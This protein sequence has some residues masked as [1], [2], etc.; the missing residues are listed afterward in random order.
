MHLGDS[1]VIQE[2]SWKARCLHQHSGS[3]WDERRALNTARRANQ[4]D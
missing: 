4:R 1:S 3:E 2:H